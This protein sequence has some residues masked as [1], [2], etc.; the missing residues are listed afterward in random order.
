MLPS[1]LALVS[2]GAAALLQVTVAAQLTLLHGPADLVLLTLLGWA[3]RRRL[4]G[5]WVWGLIAG[6]LV[7]FAS[8]LPWWLMLAA[9]LGAAGLAAFLPRRMWEVAWLNL[10]TAV[11]LGTFLVH[12]LAYVYLWVL[13]TP[14]APVQAL[15]LVI[16][17]SLLLNL[18]LA[19]PVYG[20][21]GEFAKVFYP[22]E[23]ANE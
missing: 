20:L 18:L 21:M 23:I 22:Q 17:P 5:H 8:Q 19:L 4:P 12:G 3:L 7:G 1:L 9:Y 10:F 14:I 6:L 11:L 16:L 2:L 15:N 13:R